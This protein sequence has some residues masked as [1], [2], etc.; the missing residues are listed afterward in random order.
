MRR[1]LLAALL[2][3]L[4]GCSSAYYMHPKMDPGIP[5]DDHY[6]TVFP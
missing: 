5:V 6:G 4:A 2:A 1:I 3:A